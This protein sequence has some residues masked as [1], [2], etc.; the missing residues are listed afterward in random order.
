V[1][2]VMY[3]LR[4]NPT[5]ED[6]PFA[7]SEDEAIRLNKI[8]YGIFRAVNEFHKRRKI[9]EIKNILYW[10]VDID[11][12]SKAEQLL[13]IK[14][15]PLYPSR[16]VESRNGYHLYFRAS[17]ASV[18]FYKIIMKGLVSYFGGDPRAAI[19]TAILREPGFYHAKNSKDKF[20][21]K[22]ILNI[23][24]RYNDT[25]M[26]YFFGEKPK[27]HVNISPIAVKSENIKID[28]LTEFLNNLDNMEALKRL[29]GSGYVGGEVYDFKPVGRNRFNILVNA[30]GTSCFIDEY[31]RIGATPGGPTIFQWLRYFN[32]SDSTIF[33]ILK[34]LYGE[35]K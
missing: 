12:K 4:E 30:K 6:A 16:I 33:R 26:L 3:A 13:K 15:S 17:K 31:K 24:A 11:D 20:L 35:V 22:E 29:S 19:M 32:H 10:H 21:V 9:S 18:D 8:G 28:N 1:G 14:A 5:R 25:D 34:E 2:Q 23:G 27:I 7:V